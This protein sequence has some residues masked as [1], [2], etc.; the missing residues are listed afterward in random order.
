M[1]NFPSFRQFLNESI[2]DPKMKTLDPMIFDDVSKKYPKIRKEIVN[3]IL[4]YAQQF[5]QVGPIMKIYIIGS[6]LTKHYTPNSD[7]DVTILMPNETAFT[8]EISGIIKSL[9]GKP[10]I[11]T[12][13][14]INFYVDTI[15]GF[16]EDRADNIYDILTD[17]WIKT[18]ENYDVDAE[19]FMNEFIDK[20][21]KLDLNAA[22]IRR[23]LIDIKKINI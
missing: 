11:G 13:H 1:K 15:G 19:E 3:Q 21:S 18:T 20:V 16:N 5:S 2:L 6:I 7:I 9:N 4:V 23:D 12:G 14:P 10:A 17:T 22:Q 8:D